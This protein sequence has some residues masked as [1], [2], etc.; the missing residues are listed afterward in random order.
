LPLEFVVALN[1]RT[2]PVVAVVVLTVGGTTTLVT[3]PQPVRPE[4]VES[5]AVATEPAHITT[6]QL[7]ARVMDS[8]T[9]EVVAVVPDKTVTTTPSVVMAVL[10]S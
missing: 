8:Q 10:E 4:T 6:G 2:S 3:T 7:L 1:F 5:A 9:P